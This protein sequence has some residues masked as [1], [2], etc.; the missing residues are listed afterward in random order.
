VLDLVALVLFFF[1]Y[2]SLFN[3]TVVSSRKN[4]IG[5]VFTKICCGL[6]MEK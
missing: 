3:A 5:I 2:S 6:F 1:K 4:Y